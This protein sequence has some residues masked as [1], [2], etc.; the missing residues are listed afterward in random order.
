MMVFIGMG[1]VVN[2]IAFLKN[3]GDT[4]LTFFFK[5]FHESK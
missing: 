2:D 5:G 3:I 4:C 1:Y